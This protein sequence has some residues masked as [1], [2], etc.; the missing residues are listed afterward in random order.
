MRDLFVA[1]CASAVVAL[2]AIIAY[3][4]Y[5][6]FHKP[7]LTTTY[8]AVTLVNGTVFYG[9][10]DHLG[11]DHPV[12]RDAFSLREEIDP[13]TRQTK[14][15]IVLRREGLTGADHLILPASAIAVV[16]PVTTESPLGRLINETWR[17]RPR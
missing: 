14:H 2:L 9:R 10:I 5:Q 4:N 1:A 13:T 15:V 3:Q 8:Q 7:L 17:Q 6:R 11:T 12:L 16:E